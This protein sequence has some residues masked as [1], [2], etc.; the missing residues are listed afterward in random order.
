ME[1][2]NRNS[3]RM[4]NICQKKHILEL[5]GNLRL[6][7]E[8]HDSAEMIEGQLHLSEKLMSRRDR[9][10]AQR[11]FGKIHQRLDADPRPMRI[12]TFVAGEL[13]STGI[14]VGGAV[15]FAGGVEK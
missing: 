9:R 12:Q 1:N 10:S 15:F 13:C 7:Y 3:H 5:G 2:R 6:T 14:E 8:L 11:W 4:K